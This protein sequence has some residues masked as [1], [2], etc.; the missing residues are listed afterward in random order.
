RTT[1]ELNTPRL[2]H[3]LSKPLRKQQQ[4]TTRSLSLRTNNEYELHHRTTPLHCS[5]PPETPSLIKDARGVTEI[6][7]QTTDQKTAG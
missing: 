2:T 1:L 6:G 5:K 7:R 3:T 4:A